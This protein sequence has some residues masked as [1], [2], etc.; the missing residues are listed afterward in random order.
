MFLSCVHIVL[1]IGE[2]TKF[3]LEIVFLSSKI[4]GR[5]D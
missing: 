5:C 1:V 3:V 4:I 2:S